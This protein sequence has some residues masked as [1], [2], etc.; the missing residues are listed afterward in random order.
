[1]SLSK[2]LKNKVIQMRGLIINDSIVIERLMDTCLG[3]YFTNDDEKALELL[4]LVFYT[5]RMSFE[6]KRQILQYLLQAHF[7]YLLTENPTFI[8]DMIHIIEVRNIVAHLL[9]EIP[10]DQ[11]DLSSPIVF[12]RHKNELKFE[13]ISLERFTDT[14]QKMSRCI[15]VLNTLADKLL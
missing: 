14:L 15:D 8:K 2:N 7:P 3:S 9:Y 11:E 5:E 10:E 4:Q 12:M 6:S 13:N 1:M